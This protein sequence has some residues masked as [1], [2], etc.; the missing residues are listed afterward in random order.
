[1]SAWLAAYAVGVCL[2]FGLL[3]HTACEC[4]AIRRWTA[5]AGLALLW[6]PLLLAFVVVGLSDIL[7]G[8]RND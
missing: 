8:P 6:P 4:S 2:V 3:F 1:M 5:S 7:S